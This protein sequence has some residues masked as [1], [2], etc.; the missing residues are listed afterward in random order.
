MKASEKSRTQISGAVT[1]ASK[2]TDA[3]YSRAST[4]LT[5]KVDRYMEK[6]REEKRGHP[7]DVREAMYDPLLRLPTTKTNAIGMITQKPNY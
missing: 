1:N 5:V 7:V 4:S 2:H 3:T 6:L